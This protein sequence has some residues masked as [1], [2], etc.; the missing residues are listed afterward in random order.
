MPGL[1][2]PCL[3]TSLHLA[4]YVSVAAAPVFVC[5]ARKLCGGRERTS[6]LYA[7]KIVSHIRTSSGRPSAPRRVP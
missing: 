6:R 5:V 2:E 1:T 3:Q 7:H 4:P